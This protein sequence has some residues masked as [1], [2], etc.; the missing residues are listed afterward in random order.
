M[1]KNKNS[2]PYTPPPLSQPPGSASCWS[3]LAGSLLTLVILAGIFGVILAG[4]ENSTKLDTVLANSHEVEMAQ[5]P[6]TLEERQTDA[7]V[8]V[9]EKGFQSNMTIAGTG[10]AAVSS[11][12]WAH[13]FQ[14]FGIA[15][16]LVAVAVIVIV[17]S[18]KRKNPNAGSFDEPAGI[19]VD[20]PTMSRVDRQK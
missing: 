16:A 2:I 6:K 1:L 4:V 17:L 7:I 18:S 19:P 20:I 9:A 8:S 10:F 12:T 14:I 13:T 5:A 3:W 15:L 11:I